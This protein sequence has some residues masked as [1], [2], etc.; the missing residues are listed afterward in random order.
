MSF[1]P[2]SPGGAARPLHPPAHP[3]SGHPGPPRSTPI[4][5]FESPLPGNTGAAPPPR[6]TEFLS[7]PAA[8]TPSM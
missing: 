6:P 8:P 2:P 1:A 7:A 4:P 3:G 5:G